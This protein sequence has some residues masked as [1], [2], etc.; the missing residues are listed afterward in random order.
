[1]DTNIGRNRVDSVRINM[2]SLV[3]P[4][5]PVPLAKGP[6]PQL[7]SGIYARDALLRSSLVG[8]PNYNGPV[9]GLCSFRYF[10]LNSIV[11]TRDN[12]RS[13]S[14]ARVELCCSWDDHAIVPTASDTFNQR[15]RWHSSASRRRVYRCDTNARRACDRKRS[16]EDKRLLQRWRCGARS[17][18]A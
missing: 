11:D 17:C 10:D 15:R 16:C 2:D 1:M 13:A 7:G 8:T 18:C 5:Q 14:P 4:G 9:G 12:A 3:L 6:V